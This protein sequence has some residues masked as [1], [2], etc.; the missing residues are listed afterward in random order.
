MIKFKEVHLKDLADVSTGHAFKSKNF[1]DKG[2]FV[3]RTLN[4]GKN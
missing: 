2:V 4:I 1:K 3:L